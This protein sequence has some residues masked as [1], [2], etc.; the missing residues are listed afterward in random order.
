MK[1]AESTVALATQRSYS[2]QHQTEL[3]IQIEEAGTAAPRPEV[4]LSETGKAKAAQAVD[5]EE[6]LEN[7]PRYQ[8]VKILVE[9]LTGKEMKLFHGRLGIAKG[10]AAPTQASPQAVE[11]TP[12]GGIA[13][14]YREVYEESESVQFQAAG[15]IKTSDGKEIEFS[16]ELVMSRSFREELSFSAASGSLARP[17]KDPLVI[18][19]NAPAATL[20][21]QTF[22]F[23]LDADGQ[24]DNISLL[25]AGSAFLVLDRNGDG[26]VNDGR[27][28]F[29]PQ[30]G[31][32]FADLANLDGDGNRWIDENDA[33]FAQLRLWIKDA[34]GTDK[35][36]NLQS[37][38]IGAIYLGNAKAD[39]SLNNAQNQELGQARAAG[40]YLNE[41]GSGGTVQQIDLAV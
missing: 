25:N 12:E 36:V 28:L 31:D 27:E 39:F 24:K 19:Y 4:S 34:S 13:I 2:S 29:G 3:N 8:L 16:A 41:D 15:I 10:T 14:D 23:D 9:F 1:I 40:I 21:E 33:A 30:S 37:Q 7:D 6:A 22:A 5:P 17:K 32:G 20:S 18:N 38:G 35:L 11:A 26:K